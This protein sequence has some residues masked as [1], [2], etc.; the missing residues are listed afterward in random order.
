MQRRRKP[1]Y[2]DRVKSEPLRCWF[3]RSHNWRS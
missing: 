1:I 3:R 2:M